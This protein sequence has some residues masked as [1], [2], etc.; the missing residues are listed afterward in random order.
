MTSK[1]TSDEPE[2]RATHKFLDTDELPLDHMLELFACSSPT[3]VLLCAG[4]DSIKIYIKAGLMHWVTCRDESNP[5]VA[6]ERIL[7]LGRTKWD[8]DMTWDGVPV[9]SQPL[10][11]SMRVFLQ[12]VN[13]YV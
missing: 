8:V 9:T 3:L 4:H 7:E 11:V 10:D 12:G 6:L 5:H 1:S 13:L 2:A